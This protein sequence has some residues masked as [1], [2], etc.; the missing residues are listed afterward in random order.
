MLKLYRHAVIKCRNHA[1]SSGRRLSRINTKDQCRQVSDSEIGLASF[2]QK[3]HPVLISILFVIYNKSKLVWPH[4]HLPLISHPQHAPRR[5][6]MGNLYNMLV[7]H[8]S[9]VHPL[10]AHGRWIC[11]P[12]TLKDERRHFNAS[13]QF[14]R[15]RDHLIHVH[16]VHGAHLMP[17]WLA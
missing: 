8:K 17:H 3:C 16:I 6:L 10:I 12:W 5:G 1:K 14:S 11:P 9:L 13:S 15:L 2:A 7:S 4:Q